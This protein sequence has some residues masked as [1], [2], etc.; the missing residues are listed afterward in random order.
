ML[1]H[2]RAD[3]QRITT[4]SASNVGEEILRGRFGLKVFHVLCP[5]CF[6]FK[7]HQFVI[8]VSDLKQAGRRT[9]CSL[10]KIDNELTDMLQSFSCWSW[11]LFSSDFICN[12]NV[13]NLK[14][15]ELSLPVKSRE[16]GETKIKDGIK[17]N[18]TLWNNLLPS[19]GGAVHI[20][21]N[22]CV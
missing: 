8:R 3:W 21:Q 9:I 16:S 5:A 10:D 20:Q 17:D 2:R 4:T 14:H 18:D 1:L 6:K 22:V 13:L 11:P 7:L 12:G 15:C 19:S